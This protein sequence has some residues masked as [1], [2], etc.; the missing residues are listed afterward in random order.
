MYSLFL[1]LSILE[2]INDCLKF[3]IRNLFC[4]Y[5]SSFSLYEFEKR[6]RDVLSVVYKILICSLNIF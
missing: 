5:F 6:L 1:C 2:I 3:V 4:I